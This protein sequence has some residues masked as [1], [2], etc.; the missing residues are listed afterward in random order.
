VMGLVAT[1]AA[2][3]QCDDWHDA[4][5]AYLR[6]NR[7]L[8]VE[9]INAIDGLTL[10]KPDA[11]FLAWVD[12]SGLKVDNVLQWAEDRG[13]G[14]SPGADFHKPDHFRI[15]FGCSRAMLTDIVTRL[16]K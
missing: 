8:V 15:N 5:L 16:A 11:T 9:A 1:Q 2:F 6:E 12:G 10:I 3:T 7:A 4:E 13:V 14:P